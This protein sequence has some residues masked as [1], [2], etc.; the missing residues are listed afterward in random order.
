MTDRERKLRDYQRERLGLI[1]EMDELRSQRKTLENKISKKSKKLTSVGQ[2]I[3]DL[4]HD[5]NTPEITDH[6]IVRYLERVEKMDI[7]DLKI[8]VSQ[9]KQAV[10]YGNVIVTIN[11]DWNEENETASNTTA[12]TKV[13]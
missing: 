2:A 4:K 7:N 13:L 10:K 8:K 1:A 6:A 11:A 3:Y 5:G 9:H 12:D